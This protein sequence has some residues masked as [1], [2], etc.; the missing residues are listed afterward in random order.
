MRSSR[1]HKFLLIP[2]RYSRL[3]ASILFAVTDAMYRLSLLVFAG[4]PISAKILVGLVSV[5]GQV[6]I[7][8][9]PLTDATMNS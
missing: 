2:S 9:S 1:H 7:D 6:T 4:C 3:H 5:S 8:G